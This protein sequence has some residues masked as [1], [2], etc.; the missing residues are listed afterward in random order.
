MSA[1]T[2][3][4]GDATCPQAKG[5]KLICHVCNDLGKW[6]KGFV[7]GLS[8]RWNQ[9]QEAYRTWYATGR[10]GGFELGATQFVQVERLI[11]VANMVA[12]R[13]T[14]RG[15]KGAPI[16]YDALIECLEKVAVKA[17]ELDASIHMPRIGCGLGE[18]S[19][20]KIEPILERYLVGLSIPV[21]VYD[22]K[23]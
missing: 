9:P 21:M 8:D 3:L 15:S 16:R 23:G 5:V 22:Y 10:K 4:K 7:V 13:G 11:W 14:K 1:I 6:G 20:K 19:W 2:Y 17:Q 12:Q 18:G